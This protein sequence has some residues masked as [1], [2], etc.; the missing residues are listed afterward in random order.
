MSTTGATP[1]PWVLTGHP[2]SL[3]DPST[4]VTLVDGQTFCLSSRTG[5]FD[6]NPTHG[7][8]FADMRVL[9]QA[10]LLVGGSPV[11]ALAVD[12]PDSGSATFVGRFQPAGHPELRLM[13]VRRRELGSVWHEQIEVRNT[14]P[15]AVSIAVDLEIAADFADVFAIKEGREASEGEHSIEV[16]DQS[17]LFGWRLGTSTVRPSCA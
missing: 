2:T 12:Q 10:R 11:E 4:L 13:V 6:T 7:V 1:S 3:G 14:S 5:D 17:L 15:S 16:R 8:F 9:S